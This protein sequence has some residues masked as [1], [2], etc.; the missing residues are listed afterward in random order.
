MKCARCAHVAICAASEQE[1]AKD[2][3]FLFFFSYGGE[4]RCRSALWL[5]IV[6]GKQGAMKTIIDAGTSNKS[7]EG[8]ETAR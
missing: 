4:T 2:L 6:R 1:K 7:P 3:Y 8:E 5:K